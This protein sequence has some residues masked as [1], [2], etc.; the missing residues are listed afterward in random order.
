MTSNNPTDIRKRKNDHLKISLSPKAQIGNPGFSNYR[1]VHNALPEINFDQ[2]DTKTS[3]LGKKVNLPFFISCMTG[4]MEEGAR[5]NKCL[6]SAA[7]K[8][9]IAMGVGSQRIAIENPNLKKQFAVRK[10][11]PDI[12][13]LANMGLVQLNYGF[14][15]IQIKELVDM[16][17]ADA[18]VFH[19]NPIQEAIQPEGD[20]NFEKLLPKLKKVINKLSTPIIIK[21]V[22]FGLSEDV[23]RKLY[24]AGVRIVDTAGWGGTNWAYVEGNRRNIGDIGETFSEWGIPTTESIK[25]AKRIKDEGNY[26]KM[27]ILGSGG[28]RTGI[29]IAKAISLGADL[30]GIA[31]P[32]AKAA[33]KSEKETINLIEKLAQE[34]KVSMFGVGAKTISELS[35]IPLTKIRDSFN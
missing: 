31:A 14:A 19:I 27:I 21:E 8:T 16:V 28:I 10:Y 7:Q 32:F 1:F 18:L 6:A 9:G 12:P 25:A 29:D 34:L 17:K 4:G 13:I 30:V 23:I 35:N 3:F 24:K 2:I 22:G 11:A 26:K 20:R 5:M 33:M 15:I